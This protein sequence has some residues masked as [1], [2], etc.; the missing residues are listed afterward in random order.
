MRIIVQRKTF[1]FT[2]FLRKERGKN[3]I[4]HET[5]KKQK[6]IYSVYRFSYVNL[7]YSNRHM[8]R[9]TPYKP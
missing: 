8:D 4:L 2:F 5:T 6:G 7:P 3:G 9:L 1:G